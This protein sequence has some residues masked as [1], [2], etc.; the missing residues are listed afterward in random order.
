MPAC[1]FKHKCLALFLL[2]WLPYL[3]LHAQDKYP[4]RPIEVVNQYPPGGAADTSFRAIQPYLMRELGVPLVVVTKAGAGGEIGANYVKVAAPD[5]Y[6]VLNAGNASLTTARATNPDITY[7]ISDFV[8]IGR[9]SIDPSIIVAKRGASW[10]TLDQF[11]AYA[12]A[13]PGKVTYGNGGSGGAGHI[14]TE[15][16]RHALGISMEAVPFKGSG[17]LKTAIL[18][19]HIDLATGNFS[20]FLSSVEAGQVIPLVTSLPRRYPGLPDV[21][22]LAEAGVPQAALD[23]Y[24]SLMVPNGTPAPIIARLSAALE[25]VMNNPEAI[26]QLEKVKLVPGYLDGPAT[27]QVLEK[28]YEKAMDT[29]KNFKVTK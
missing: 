4:A 2:I 14:M 24:M 7:K 8:V 19:G 26:G 28:E 12:K 1:N 17:P 22:T 11:I 18:G 25:R 13:N 5:G 3:P 29:V 9:Y 16:F 15:I 10:K 6:T 27:V 23:T 21:P 20:T